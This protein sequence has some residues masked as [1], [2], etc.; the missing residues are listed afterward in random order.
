MP[1]FANTLRDTSAA[2][3]LS[4]AAFGADS[5]EAAKRYAGN[6]APTNPPHGVELSYLRSGSNA[7][8]AVGGAITIGFGAWALSQ[9]LRK[10][11]KE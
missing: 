11:K 8:L 7:E 1:S 6:V 2:L 10:D 4:S 9:V 5:S 3:L